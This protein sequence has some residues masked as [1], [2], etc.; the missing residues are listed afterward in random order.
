MSGI[1]NGLIGPLEAGLVQ[2]VLRRRSLFRFTGAAVNSFS[3]YLERRVARDFDVAGALLLPSASTALD[4]ILEGLDLPPNATIA[5]L[6]LGWAA[7]YSA[8]LRRGLTLDFLRYQ[9]LFEVDL[10]HLERQLAR[11][12]LALLVVPHLLGRAVRNIE[13]VA[14]VS[15]QYGVPLVEDVAQ[16]FGTTIGGRLVGSFGTAAYTSFNHHKIMSA[17]DGGL[18]IFKDAALLERAWRAHDQGCM[19]GGNTR[20][21]DPLSFEPGTS[22]RVNELTAAVLVGQ[23]A[24]VYQIRSRISRIHAEVARQLCA[25]GLRVLA[26]QPGDLPFTALFERPPQMDYPSLWDSGWHVFS[27]IPYAK[28][29]SARLDQ[30]DRA[31]VER[32]LRAVASVGCGFI[33]KYFATPVGIELSTGADELPACVAAV[34]QEVR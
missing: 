4:L 12:G 10:E 24:R 18:A 22:L 9:S 7:I 17:G 34:L 1:G 21:V 26:P 23:Y 32:Q 31:L 25:R 27:R 3:H 13:D 2:V 5:T 15:R 11:G 33:D 20:R 30:A 8:V 19:P 29:I 6:P 28:E 16:S 14:R